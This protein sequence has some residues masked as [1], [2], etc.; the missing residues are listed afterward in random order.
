MD[1]DGQSTFYFVCAFGSAFWVD[2][3]S[4]FFFCVCVC[5]LMNA[6]YLGVLPRLYLF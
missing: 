2:E 6:Y 1:D 5:V 4:F 3:C